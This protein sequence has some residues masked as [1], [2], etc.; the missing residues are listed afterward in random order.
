MVGAAVNQEESLVVIALNVLVGKVN[1]DQ[2]QGL[3]RVDEEEAAVL[4]KFQAIRQHGFGRM[5]VT[6]L[7]HQLDTLHKTDT[8]KKKDLIKE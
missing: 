4:D 8:F 6:V 5:E 1:P 3:R 7:H 2:W